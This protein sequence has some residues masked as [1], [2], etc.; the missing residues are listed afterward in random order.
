MTATMTSPTYATLGP[1]PEPLGVRAEVVLDRLA[2]TAQ[3][4]HAPKLCPLSQALGATHQC[5]HAGCPFYRVP[6][7]YRECAV[8]QWAPGVRRDHTMARWFIARRAEI[9]RGR[10]VPRRPR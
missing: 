8:E 7:T 1:D 6:G 10:G 4:P 2:S 3:A 9:L 5:S